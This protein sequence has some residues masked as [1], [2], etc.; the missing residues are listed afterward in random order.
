M[1][2]EGAHQF[3]LFG[4]SIERAVEEAIELRELIASVPARDI[5]D[6]KAMAGLEAEANEK[7]RT[8]TAIA[9]A[10]IG[11]AFVGGSER[12]NEARLVALGA[13]ADRVLR[14]D[15]EALAA[16]ERRT[17]ADLSDECTRWEDAA[18]VPLAAPV[19]RS[20]LPTARRS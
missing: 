3:R 4:Q 19:P 12:E 17:A 14:G 8:A 18:A 7:L 2:P 13:D 10:L 1:R 9:D 5:R 6:V 16:L 11:T 15:A 20:I